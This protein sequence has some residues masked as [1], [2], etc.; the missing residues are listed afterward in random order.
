M[1]SLKEHKG[2]IIALIIFLLVIFVYKLLFSSNEELIESGASAQN[3]GQDIIALNASI[4]R[5]NLD[6]PLFNSRPFKNLIDFT[7]TVPPQPV[8]RNNPFDV[9]GR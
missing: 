5:I 6:S 9:I 7:V 4:S 8:G 2:K 3:I 1:K